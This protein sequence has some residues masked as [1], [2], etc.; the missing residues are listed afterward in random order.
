[1]SLMCVCVC[2]CVC[3][4]VWNVKTGLRGLFVGNLCPSSQSVSDPYICPCV[5][6]VTHHQ[7]FPPFSENCIAESTVVG[8][9]SSAAANTFLVERA[10]VPFLSQFLCFYLPFAHCSESENLGCYD[11]V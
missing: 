2:E 3:V 8:V 10:D 11:F 4:C 9:S 1:V 6:V 5:S 7:Y